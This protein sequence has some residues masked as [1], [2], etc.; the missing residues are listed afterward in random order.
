MPLA[1][2]LYGNILPVKTVSHIGNASCAFRYEVPKLIVF[3]R[4]EGELVTISLNLKCKET[5]F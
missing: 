1:V 4:M 5:D 2:I 3:M